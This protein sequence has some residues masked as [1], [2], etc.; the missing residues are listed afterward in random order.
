M[1]DELLSVI[2]EQRRELTAI[3][4]TKQRVAFLAHEA[5]QPVFDAIDK[6]LE[7]QIKYLDVT[8]A[9]SDSTIPGT[10]KYA[11]V[12]ARKIVQRYL[13]VMCCANA[14]GRYPRKEVVRMLEN[15]ELK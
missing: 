8:R 14:I 9:L 1:T 13:E 5:Y 7:E 15:G 2:E 12:Y 11:G 3:I 6:C 10:K 4:E